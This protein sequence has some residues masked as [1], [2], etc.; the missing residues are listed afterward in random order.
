MLERVPGRQ[1]RKEE[2]TITSSHSP[3]IAGLEAPGK[4]ALGDFK[5]E[6][7]KFKFSLSFKI[8]TVFVFSSQGHA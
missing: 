4:C 7:F 6:A 1:N 2:N 3:I 8:L 5:L